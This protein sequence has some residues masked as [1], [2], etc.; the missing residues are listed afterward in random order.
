MRDSHKRSVGLSVYRK[1]AIWRLVN[2]LLEFIAC[3]HNHWVAKAVC[4]TEPVGTVGWF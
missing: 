3:C 2:T 4:S 1:S